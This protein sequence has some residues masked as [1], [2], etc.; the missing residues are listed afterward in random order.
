MWNIGESL[1]TAIEVSLTIDEELVLYCHLCDE[2]PWG[3]LI[4]TYM[5]GSSILNTI[6]MDIL[7]HER[8]QHQ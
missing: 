5:S 1:S 4:K 3:K 2:K 7:E 6:I 8:E